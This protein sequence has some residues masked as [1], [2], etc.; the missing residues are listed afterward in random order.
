MDAN[1][2]IFKRILDDADFQ[3]VLADF[4]VRKMYGGLRS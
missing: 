2:E 3:S 4:Y 1:E